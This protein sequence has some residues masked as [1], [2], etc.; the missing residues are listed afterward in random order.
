M[1]RGGDAIMQPSIPREARKVRNRRAADSRANVDEV[2]G[3]FERFL[4]LPVP[5]VLAAMWLAGVV[6]LGAEVLTLYTLV[7]LLAASTGGA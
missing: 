3:V 7:T 4:R 5:I 6:L 2:S 1:L